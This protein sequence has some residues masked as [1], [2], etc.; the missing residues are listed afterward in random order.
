MTTGIGIWA[1][2]WLPRSV[3]SSR[4][5]TEEQKQVAGLRMAEDEAE[6]SWSEGLQALRD[7]KV[8]VFGFSALLYGVGVASS[9]NFLPVCCTTIFPVDSK[10]GRQGMARG[11]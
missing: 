8:W 3:Q 1:L 5:F 10:G 9:S 2:I 6:F 4:L 11:C 7:W